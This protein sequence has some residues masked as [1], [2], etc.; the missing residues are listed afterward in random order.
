MKFGFSFAILPDCLVYVSLLKLAS[1]FSGF[2]SFRFYFLLKFQL[3]SRFLPNPRLPPHSII[4]VFASPL[5]PS[6]PLFSQSLFKVCF[7]I[8][9]FL[10][11]QF[12]GFVHRSRLSEAQIKVY[13]S[14][15]TMSIRFFKNKEKNIL[16]SHIML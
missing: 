5:P 1:G 6:L 14:I 15:F 3:S 2:F 4:E 16:F 12:P 13:H 8:L 7:L 10:I 9:S 11:I